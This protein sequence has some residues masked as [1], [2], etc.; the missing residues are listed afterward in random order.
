MALLLERLRAHLDRARLF[1]APGSA[2]LAVSG[3]PDSVALL[4][5]MLAVARERGLS[6]VVAHADHGIRADSRTVGQS[7]GELAR[8]S[9]LPFELGEL[10]LG[11]GATETAARRARYAWLALVQRRHAA[12]YLVT[13]HHADDQVETILLRVLKGSG[14]AG[15]AGMPARG[16]GGIVRPLLP[17]SR[18][19][20]AVHVAE[21]GLAFHDDPANRDPRH[22]RSWLR[23]TLLPQLVTRLGTNLRADVLRLGRAAAVERR[24]WDRALE[25]VPELRLQRSAGGFDVARAP[26]SRYDKALSAA[27]LRAAARRVG[28]VLGTRRARRLLALAGRPSGRRLSLGA[29]WVAEVAF[30]R[31]RV[32]RGSSGAATPIVA[33]REK[34]SA[35][36]GGFRVEWAP[37]PAPARLPRSDWTT[38]IAGPRWEVRAPRP[39]DRLVP[40]GGVGHRPVRRLLM[41]AR[42]PRSSRASYPVVARG[43]TILWVPGICRSAADLPRPGTRAVRLHVTECDESQADGRA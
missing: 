20:L 1:P 5:L 9:G 40:V 25:L 6:L 23:V 13:A 26:L 17:F 36:F 2:V 22:L 24:A 37:G 29:G 7:V 34:G 31:L 14:P 43:E 30:D 16:R 21:R 12:R 18:A 33:S 15:L 3:G 41:E 35:L 19:E 38:W 27:L 4:D 11:P 42:V 39:G 8:R 28:L 10:E 32:Y